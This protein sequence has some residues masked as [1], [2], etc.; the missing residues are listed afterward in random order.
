MNTKKQTFVVALATATD[1]SKQYSRAETSINRRPSIIQKLMLSI[2][3]ISLCAFQASAQSSEDYN[4]VEFYGGFSHNRVQPNTE[5]FTAFGSTLAPCS[6][7]ATEVLGENYQTSFC[8]RRGFNGF[9]T[10]ITYNF[11]R[12]LGI[13]GNV[14]GHYK[15]DRFVDTFGP[16]TVTLNTR[17][18]VHNFLVGVQVKDNH[19]AARFKPFAHALFG[20]A[21]YNFRGVNTSDNP[22]NNYTLRSNVTSFAMKLGGGIDV[23]VNRRIDIRL[24]GLDYNPVFTRD[25]DITGAPYSLTQQSKTAHNFTIGFGITFH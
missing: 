13:K 8:Q 25:Y 15:S 12:Y 7:E 10:S 11:N 1:L 18:R 22:D 3:F 24:I 19:K 16:E 23:R 20:A 2:L 14:T 5:T 17:D 21:R 4:K 6:S 9:D